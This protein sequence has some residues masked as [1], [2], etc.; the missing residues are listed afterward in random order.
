MI[1]ARL[2]FPPKPL[3]GREEV[4]PNHGA[5]N[6]NL[7]DAE[8]RVLYL[9]GDANLTALIEFGQRGVGDGRLIDI[10]AARLRLAN[11]SLGSSSRICRSC[12]EYIVANSGVPAGER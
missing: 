5:R 6:V 1:K 11:I 4:I 8:L 9:D 12:H 7:F 2:T 10:R 3:V